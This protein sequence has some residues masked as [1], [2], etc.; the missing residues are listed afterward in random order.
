MSQG[1]TL[2]LELINI[3]IIF[4]HFGDIAAN[5]SITLKCALEIE[6]EAGIKMMIAFKCE[7]LWKW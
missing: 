2:N 3:I 1:Q 5:E 7:I 4:D 6:C